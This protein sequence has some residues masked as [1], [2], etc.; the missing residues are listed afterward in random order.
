MPIYNKET[1]NNTSILK[2]QL[3]AEQHV[4]IVKPYCKTSSCLEVKEVSRR[5][6]WRNVKNT[7]EKKQV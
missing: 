2:M 6:I 7:K 5:R 4:F 3:T 1:N